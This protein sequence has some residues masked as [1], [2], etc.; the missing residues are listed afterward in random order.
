ME[1]TNIRLKKW[2]MNSSVGRKKVKRTVLE[3]SG[4]LLLVL[5]GIAFCMDVI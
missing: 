1:E 2:P 4:I 3:V 5:F